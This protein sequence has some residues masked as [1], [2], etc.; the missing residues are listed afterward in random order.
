MQSP[1]LGF[2]NVGQIFQFTVNEQTVPFAIGIKSSQPG[3]LQETFIYRFD[4]TNGKWLIDTTTLRDTVNGYVYVIT[5][6][7]NMPFAALIDTMR[8]K[9]TIDTST[10]PVN[11]GAVVPYT[12]NVSDNVGNL[13]WKFQY[14]SGGTPYSIL[15]EV[16]ST[17]TNGNYS[18]VLSIPNN[19]TGDDN[20]ALARFITDDGTFKDTLDLSRQVIRLKSD[21]RVTS[22]MK[23][24][25][26]RVTAVLDSPQAQRLLKFVDSTN[27]VY[28]NAYVRL[29][30]WYP[31]ASNIGIPDRWAEYTAAPATAPDN[32]FDFISGRLMWIKTRQSVVLD[33]GRAVTMPQTAPTMVPLN[34][35]E[36]TDFALPYR[37]NMRV[38]DILDATRA[39][40]VNA[41][42]LQIY[43]WVEDSTGRFGAQQFYLSS[44]PGENSPG[45]LMSCVGDAVGFTVFNPLGS[46]V[47]LVMP[48]I[49]DLM[50]S[51]SSVKAKSATGTPVNRWAVKVLP[52]TAEGAVLTPVYCGYTTSRSEGKIVYPVAPGFDGIG[53]SVVD[54]N[55]GATYGD[56]M[57]SATTGGGCSYLLVFN[58]D[59]TTARTI[60]ISLERAGAFPSTM[61]MVAYDVTTGETKDISQ[62][63][64]GLS[65]PVEAEGR[66]YRWLLVGT[67]QYI[68]TAVREHPGVK[69]ALTN[70]YPNPVR[71]F[72]HLLY[73]LPFGQ[74]ANVDFTVLD[75][76]GRTIWHKS[77]KES[78]VIG[79]RR[80]F[81][82]Y[83][84]GMNGR[85]V[86]A[87]V[88]VL[89]MTALNAKGKSIGDFDRRLTVLP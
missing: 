20:G 13:R 71:R 79:G 51:Y 26:L 46:V 36:Y 7:L 14:T 83:G 27:P 87:G 73:T 41:D 63:G 64:T 39:S 12:V 5:N 54:E 45:G 48:P 19:Y 11:K 35:R 58:N 47:N 9:V 77:I 31:N 86:A 82:W 8:P 70:V 84:T 65:V 25:P 80:D 75:I 16:D 37:Y 23:W 4:S 50:S 17:L 53:V 40:G 24:V 22:A 44:I 28:D 30:R 76:M 10:T 33:F 38:G 2:I 1:V 32:V 6:L 69:L 68:A 88:Y 57:L 66:E 29:F 21:A 42:T 49:S 18:G 67:A 55:S 81:V 34:A 89:K 56:K 52:K 78:S 74:V 72:A 61:K 43:S 15:N 62:V 85:R 3:L 59:A 60:S